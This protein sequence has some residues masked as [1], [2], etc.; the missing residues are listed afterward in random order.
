MLA[1]ADSCALDI[2]APSN[3]FSIC[4]KEDGTYI[5]L[6]FPIY[7]NDPGTFLYVMQVE[8]VLVSPFLLAVLVLLT[9]RKS[10]KT[11]KLSKHLRK[12]MVTCMPKNARNQME[13]SAC[14]RMLHTVPVPAPLKWVS[15]QLLKTCRLQLTI[16]LIYVISL[17]QCKI[18]FVSDSVMD[19]RDVLNVRNIVIIISL[20]NLILL[21]YRYCNSCGSGENCC[22]WWVSWNPT[23]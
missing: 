6:I 22:K 5:P 12:N 23:L 13:V 21:R 11:M 20:Y 1:E 18:N 9:V 14:I 7:Q 10:E 4:I 19:Q 3:T 17:I 8:F 15:F 2:P 16:I